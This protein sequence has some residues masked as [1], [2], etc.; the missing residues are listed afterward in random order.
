MRLRGVNGYRDMG[1]WDMI[2]KTVVRMMVKIG[3]GMLVITMELV[4]YCIVCLSSVF[5][6]LCNIMLLEM[7]K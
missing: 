7:V 4:G 5:T 2:V 3:A 1:V 6:V